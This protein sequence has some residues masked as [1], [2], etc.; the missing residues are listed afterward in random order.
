MSV[1]G[2][3]SRVKGIQSVVVTGRLVL[4]WD[5]DNSLGGRTNGRGGG[6]GYKTVMETD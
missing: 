6:G 2:A 3:A 5:V 4:V 1:G